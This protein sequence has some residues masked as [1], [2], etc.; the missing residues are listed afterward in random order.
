MPLVCEFC[1]LYKVSTQR[2]SEHKELQLA[3]EELHAKAAT[4]Y[5]RQGSGLMPGE[6]PRGQF[7]AKLA[8][9]VGPFSLI[10]KSISANADVPSEVLDLPPDDREARLRDLLEKLQK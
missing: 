3:R 6:G 10:E 4:F 7:I 2:F 1:Y 8:A 9:N 5:A